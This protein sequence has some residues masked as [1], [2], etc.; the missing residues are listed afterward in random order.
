MRNTAIWLTQARPSWKSFTVRRAG[1]LAV[2]ERQAHDVDRHEARAVQD[3]GHAEAQRGRGDRGHGVEAR[4]W[5]AER[6]GRP[7]RTAG[8]AP[9][10]RPRRCP[11]RST[12]SSE[13]VQRRRSRAAVMYSMKPSTSTIATGSLKPDSPSRMRASRRSQAGAAQHRED[14]GAVGGGH[15]RAQQQALEQ[16]EV[17]QHGGGHAHDAGGHDRA[18]RGQREARC[19]G[20]AGSP[21]SPPPGRPRTG[22]ARAP[23]CRSCAPAPRPRVVPPKSIR[24]RTSDPSSI[25]TPEEQHEAG[26]AQAPRHQRGARCPAP[27][28]LPP[29]G[30][31]CRRPL[32]RRVYGRHRG[33]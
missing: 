22:S 31:A 3:V 1:M 12:V 4:W 18:D 26:H 5:T 11:A 23:R 21:G 24:P 30:S 10:P 20:R 29:R 17:E 9:G 15:D 32:S 13:H 27:A 33:R 6:A 16:R 14:R 25:P 8:R 7:A 19:R 28:A 2:P